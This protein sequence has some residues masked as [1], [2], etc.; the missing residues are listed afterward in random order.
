MGPLSRSS[1]EMAVE[2]NLE[3][4]RPRRESRRCWA[5]AAG[6]APEPRILKT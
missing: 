5:G 1:K 4:I 2:M 3:A 6:A